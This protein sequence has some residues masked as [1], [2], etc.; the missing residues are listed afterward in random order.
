MRARVVS[1]RISEPKLTRL[2]SATLWQA[3]KDTK[4]VRVRA[5]KLADRFVILS[6]FVIRAS[7]VAFKKKIKKC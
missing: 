5:E 3:R 4:G 2:R 1:Q 7:S 6:T